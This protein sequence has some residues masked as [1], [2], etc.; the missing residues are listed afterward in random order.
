MGAEGSPKNNECFLSIS[1]ILCSKNGGSRLRKCLQH[2]NAIYYDGNMQVIIVDNGS[3]DRSLEIMHEH[4]KDTPHLTKVIQTLRPGNSA[5]RN[6]ALSHATGEIIVFID[7]DCYVKTDFLTEWNTVFKKN[8]GISFGSGRIL[9]HTTTQSLLGCNSSEDEVHI[10]AKKFIPRGFIQGSNMA[11]RR[12]SFPDKSPFDERFG[13]GTP[14]AG[15]EWDLS[16]SISFNG[17]NCGYF[18]KPTV[19]HDHGRVNAEVRERLLYYD[20]GAGA[21][22][23]KHLLRRNIYITMREIISDWRKLGSDSA[24][25]SALRKGFFSLLKYQGIKK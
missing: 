15:E 17:H 21:V 10:Q 8:P 22:Y 14:F 19:F 13:A 2:I 16:L 24:R 20:F 18:P 6:A 9:P 5:G 1:L 3:T 4:S 11:F 12:T 7:D 23:A 25:R